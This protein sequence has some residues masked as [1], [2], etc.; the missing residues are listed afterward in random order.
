VNLDVIWKSGYISSWTDWVRCY[1]Y[2]AN[3]GWSG[4]YQF[5]DVKNANGQYS[6]KVGNSWHYY[7]IDTIQVVA[8]TGFFNK[9][10]TTQVYHFAYS[11]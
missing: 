11:I 6:Y 9:S 2:S 8:D 10:E 5:T 4:Y 1:D 3:T 7:D